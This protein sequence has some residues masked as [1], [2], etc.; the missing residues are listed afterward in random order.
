MLQTSKAFSGFSVA[1]L[2]DA[3]HFYAD[4]LGLKVERTDDMGGMLHLHISGNNNAI[5]V[6]PK[7][8]HQP[9]AYTILNFPV[10]DIVAAVKGLKERG[11][12]FENYDG[13]YVQTDENDIHRNGGPLIA[14]FKDPSGNYLSVIEVE[15]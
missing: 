5:L 7:P 1:N 10:R 3:Y 14:W 9:A 13:E 11:V 15:E 12:V 4:K 6:Y 2:D 8:D